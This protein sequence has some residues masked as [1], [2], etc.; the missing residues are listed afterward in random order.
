MVASIISKTYQPYQMTRM[1]SFGNY[2]NKESRTGIIKQT[3]KEVCKLHF[4]I[5]HQTISQKYDAINSQYQDAR[6][7]AVQHTSAINDK[8]TCKIDGNVYR[9]LDISPDQDTY[10]SYDLVT[11]SLIKDKKG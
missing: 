5:V 6:I 9:I 8:L 3:F 1:A 7:I 11:L 10:I 2:E 4:A